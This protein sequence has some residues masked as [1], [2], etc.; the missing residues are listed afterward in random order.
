MPLFW[1]Y[2][3]KNFFKVFGLSIFSFSF[4]LLLTRAKDIAK[5]ASL[6]SSFKDIIYF[7][8]IQIPHIL[9]LAIP[10]SSFIAA[11]TLIRN[12]SL[13]SELN[14][15]RVASLSIFQIFIPIF[16]TSLCLALI[17]FYISAE[18]TPKLRYK[19]QDFLIKKTSKNPV[20]L[21]K[22]QKLLK[23]N[24]SFV[25]FKE[26]NDINLEDFIFITYH[27]SSKRLLMLTA[28]EL[29]FTKKHLQGIGSTLISYMK[30]NEKLFD[31]LIIENQLLFSSPSEEVASI[32]KK[33]KKKLIHT[34]S[35]LKHLKLK[36]KDPISTKIYYFELFRRISL[37]VYTFIFALIGATFGLSIQRSVSKKSFTYALVCIGI[38]LTSYLSAKHLKINPSYVLAIY[39][40]PVIIISLLCINVINK[41]SKGVS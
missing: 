39:A 26:L 35:S 22:K 24:D 36:A 9:P 33:S 25:N 29:V 12:L 19:S 30:T 18:L 7:I 40:I 1:K 4:I 28:K 8:L 2:L 32:M 3:L 37:G 21:L 11:F 23:F 27:N 16:I 31:N 10:L 15:L 6:A 14:A 20:N 34:F 13:S 41:V 38:I 17:N 5:Y